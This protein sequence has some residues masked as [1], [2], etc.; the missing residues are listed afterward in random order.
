MRNRGAH[1]S[2]GRTSW[3]GK[4]EVDDYV[5]FAAFFM[6]Y[7]SY[8]HPFPPVDAN[9]SPEQSPISPRLN[10]A[11]EFPRHN[12]QTPIVVLGGYSYG[13][14]ILRHLPPVPSILQP[15]AAPHTG[16][17]A[18][19]ILLRAHKLS[20][21]SN[22]EW[23]NQARNSERQR[24]RGLE[25]KLSVT[26]GGEETSP[27]ARRSSREIR[28]SIDGRRSL[29]LGNR[30]RSISHRRRKDSAGPKTPPDSG[31]ARPDIS[32][33]D[34]RYLLISPLTPPISI[35]AAPGLG[36]KL[37]SRD[38]EPHENVGKHIS[39]AIYGDQ[40]IFT[41]ARK[42]HQWAEKLKSEQGSRFSHTEIAGAGHFWIE[43]GVEEKLRTTLREWS[44]TM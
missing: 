33:P 31:E 41:S 40:D 26:M 15:F 1:G 24:R 22:L 12:E 5:S 14:T 11:V 34:V 18:C 37:W 32:V 30:I 20:D 6:H 17:S 43:R 4:P 16:S 13:S 19:E 7:M 9:F 23:I 25:N 3:S 29:D 42:V 28:R 38:K 44:S 8:I 21:Q 27:D 39:L 10:R 36:P 2:K 35:L